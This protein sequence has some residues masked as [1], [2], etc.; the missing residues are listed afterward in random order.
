MNVVKESFL[1]D[2]Q[3]EVLTLIENG[4]NQRE[5]AELIHTSHA[6]VSMVL[7]SAYRNIE[8]AKNTLE[9]F[10]RIRAP[11]HLTINKDTDL[12]SIPGVI[13]Q[14]ADLV[15][16]KIQGGGPKLLTLIQDNSKNKIQDRRVLENLHVAVT[17]DGFILF[18]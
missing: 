5:I 13:Y 2:K 15:G 9:I 10:N 7:K 3:I 8:K 1:T 12:Y 17:W 14:E 6:N 16:I 4:H 18:D 11:L